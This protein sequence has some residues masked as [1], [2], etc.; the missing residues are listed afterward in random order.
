MEWGRFC[1]LADSFV[2]TKAA[3]KTTRPDQRYQQGQ[4]AQKARPFCSKHGYSGHATADCR[5]LKGD[6]QPARAYNNPGTSATTT[7][8]PQQPWQQQQRRQYG[9]NTL[10]GYPNDIPT[11]SPGVGSEEGN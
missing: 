1:M 7:P 9:V 8:R 6:N 3:T 4:N 10:E 5:A 2:P 11:L